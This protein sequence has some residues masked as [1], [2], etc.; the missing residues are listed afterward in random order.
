MSDRIARYG[1]RVVVAAVGLAIVGGVFYA[2]T[3]KPGP[4]PAPV[5]ECANPPCLGGGGLPSLR[6]L[7]V[8]LPVMGYGLAI[9]LGIASGIA[10]ARSLQ[11]GRR[12]A[13]GIVLPLIG[14]L[15]ILIGTE[16]VPH[17]LSPC[18]VTETGICE[19]TSE[20]VD[21]RDRWHPLDH[22]LVGALPMAGLYW[23]ALRRWRPDLLGEENADDQ[24]GAA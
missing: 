2:A 7:P 5:E 1:W 14:P 19:L 3:W 4:A 16:I 6:D 9:L 12:R 13:V 22:A 23:I 17:V 10:G 20:G 15:L 24:H 11:G 18:L 21:V 8:V